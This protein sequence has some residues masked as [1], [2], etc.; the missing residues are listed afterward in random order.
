MDLRADRSAMQWAE[1]ILRAAPPRAVLLTE[2]DAHTFTLWYAHD[3]LNA[4]P[5]VIVLDRD[6]WMY[7]PYRQMMIREF[8]LANDS[9]PE[10]AAQ[11]MARP[12]V[13]V[14]EEGIH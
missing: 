9:I 2:R 3:A 4:R 14:C 1:R 7:A 12:I 11:R 5:D 13:R 10:Q 8:G 6:L